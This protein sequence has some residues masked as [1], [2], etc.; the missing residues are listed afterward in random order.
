MAERGITLIYGGGRVGMMGAVADAAL[1]G[2][3][4]VVGVI[5]YFLNTIEL[6]HNGCTE[7]HVVESMHERKALMAKLSEGFVALPGGFGTLDEIFEVVTWSQLARHSWPCALLDFDGYFTPLL[8]CLNGMVTRGFLR[9]AD[10]DRLIS[11]TDFP[12]LLAHMNAWKPPVGT[13]WDQPAT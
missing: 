4:K 2:G 5:P 12:T 1:E 9:Q 11:D 8:E 13:K 7:L 6:A 10:R 3:G